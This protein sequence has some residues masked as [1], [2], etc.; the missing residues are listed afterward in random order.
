[1][2]LMH[3][4]INTSVQ[5]LSQPDQATFHNSKIPTNLTGGNS[6]VRKP[7]FLLR[8]LAVPSASVHKATGESMVGRFLTTSDGVMTAAIEAAVLTKMVT[9][10]AR[11][12]RQPLKTPLT[13]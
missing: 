6:V 5:I 8:L 13:K 7:R 11:S 3:Y 10:D 2:R 9:A 4:S 1:M 12:T